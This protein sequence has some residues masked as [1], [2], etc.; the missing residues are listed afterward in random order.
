MNNIKKKKRKENSSLGNSLVVQYLGLYASTAGGI[1]FI[2]SP[3]TKSPH[4]EEPKK[5]KQIQV[6]KVNH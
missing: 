2:P 4:A 3:R 1:G 5:E 6:W